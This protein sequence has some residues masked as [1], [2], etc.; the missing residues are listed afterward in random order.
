MIRPVVERFPRR[1]EI[2]T[3]DLGNPPKRHCILIVSLDQRN[4]SD[5]VDTVLMVPFSS[6][7]SDAPTIL[8]IEPGE[9]GLPG[10]SYLKC[11][12]ITT[13]PKARLKECMPRMLRG[14]R[15]SEVAAAIRRSFDPDA[16]YDP[17]KH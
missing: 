13:F 11:H 3:A 9:S 1:G 14:R 8:P 10:R 4:Q 16:P 15:M 12:F 7:G 5:R 6:S 2:W 17:P